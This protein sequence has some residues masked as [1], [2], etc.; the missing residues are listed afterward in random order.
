MKSLVL[1]ELVRYTLHLFFILSSVYELDSVV[2]LRKGP[3]Y[4]KL[5]PTFNQIVAKILTK[6]RHFLMQFVRRTIGLLKV[7]E[8]LP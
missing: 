1:L 5:C 4:L 8:M 3:I 7:F 2:A 6:R